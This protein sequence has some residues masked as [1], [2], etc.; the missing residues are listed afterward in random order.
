M[1]IVLKTLAPSIQLISDHT[2]LYI[3]TIAI[4]WDDYLE[5]KLQNN[6][7]GANIK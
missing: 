1:E 6:A 7:I 4:K 2:S 3:L 5:K